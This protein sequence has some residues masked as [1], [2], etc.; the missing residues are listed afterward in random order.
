MENSNYRQVVIDVWGD[1]ACFTRPECKVERNTYPCIT[2]SAARNLL[3]SIYMKPNEFYY[4]IEKIEVMNEIKYINIMKNELKEKIGQNF[5]PIYT[6][7]PAKE[8]GRT[9]RNTVYLKNVYY[10]IYAKIIKR[11]DW[12]GSVEAL[13]NQFNRRI[14]KGQ[15]F[16]QPYLGLR[17][18]IC[19]FSEPDLSKEVNKGINENIGNMLYDVF[20]IRSNVKLDTSK[21]NGNVTNISF[22]NACIKEGILIVP[23]YDSDDIRRSKDVKTHL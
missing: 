23:E 9:Q 7:N 4:E 1:L 6:R 11:N 8:K 13:Y 5:E 18:C 19:H 10:R 16:R 20:D 15:C 14:H 21:K 3:C 12:H 2:P 22:F 17:E